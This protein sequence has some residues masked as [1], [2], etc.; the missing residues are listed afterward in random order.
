MAVD[1]GNGDK[2]PRETINFRV[3]LSPP[4]CP[5]TQCLI[6]F[7]PAVEPVYGRQP[8]GWFDEFG[9]D[10]CGMSRGDSRLFVVNATACCIARYFQSLVD[11][12][13]R[14]I[15]MTDCNSS[16][17]STIRIVDPIPP[18]VQLRDCAWFGAESTSPVLHLPGVAVV[19]PGGSALGM[20]S[21]CRSSSQSSILSSVR[22][23]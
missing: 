2:S 11:T 3:L 6:L 15:C 8:L 20:V 10:A 14:L 21:R 9:G 4:H 13:P 18:E 23:T 12:S 7:T 1:L 19:C 22:D 5:P 16:V 17:C